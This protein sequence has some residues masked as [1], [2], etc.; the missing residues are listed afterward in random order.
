MDTP[1]ETDFY[2]IVLSP[3]LV[4]RSKTDLSDLRILDAEGRFVPYVLKEGIVD[5]GG[6]VFQAIANPAILQR[7]SSDRHSYITLTWRETY[8]IDQ[9]RWQLAILPYTSGMHGS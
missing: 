1:G 8:R 3:E 5:T 2:R 7:D 9:L 6:T 4:A